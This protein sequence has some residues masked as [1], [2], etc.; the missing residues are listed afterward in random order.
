MDE[1]K[2]EIKP[3]RK[4]YSIQEIEEMCIKAG[5]EKPVWEF[6]QGSRVIIVNDK[7]LDDRCRNRETEGK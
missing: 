3:E 5:L 1:K 7:R 4:T 2:T 6:G